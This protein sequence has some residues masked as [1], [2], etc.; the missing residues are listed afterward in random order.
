MKTIKAG[1]D[2]AVIPLV[3]ITA[4]E[5]IKHTYSSVDKLVGLGCLVGVVMCISWKISNSRL[6]PKNLT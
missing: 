3:A 1:I 4:L 5:T 6:K 2:Y